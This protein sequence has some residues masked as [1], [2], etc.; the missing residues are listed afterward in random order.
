MK[1][2]SKIFLNTKLI[3]TFAEQYHKEFDFYSSASALSAQL[4]DAKLVEKGIRAIVS[5][6]AK[7]PSRLHDKL[8][9]QFPDKKYKNVGDIYT[10]IVDLAGVRIALYFNSELDGNRSHY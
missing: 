1:K 7:N 8:K 3:D 6:R 10:D 2:E 4:I 9:K 5:S